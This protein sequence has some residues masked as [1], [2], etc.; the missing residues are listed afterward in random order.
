MLPRH[1]TLTLDARHPTRLARFWADLLGQ[2]TVADGTDGVRLPGTDTR[3]DL[4]FVPG[5]PHRTGPHRMHL[6]LT[7]D[8]P[9]DQ[10][11]QVARAIALGG[12]HLD[13]GQRPEE[14][15]VVLADP[16][17]NEFC[18]IGPGNTFLAGCGRLGE[19]ACDGTREVGLFWS[20]ALGWPLV[21]DQDQETAVQAP[22]GGTKVAWGGPPVAPQ[23][24][25]NPQRFDL[26]A[27]GTD[28]RTEVDR[29]VALGA[30]RLDATADGVVLLADPDGN[31]FGVTVG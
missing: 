31:A 1:L 6:H 29:L 3:P 21:W 7:S 13:V 27:A 2:D 19:V 4:R 10:R 5:Q 24:G 18:V 23:R 11:L 16:E 14:T 28:P 30:T 12:S 25:R 8:S 22:H 20:R 17:G 9:D 26:A 15:H